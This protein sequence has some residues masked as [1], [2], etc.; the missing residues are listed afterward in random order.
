MNSPASESD[1]GAYGSTLLNLAAECRDDPAFRERLE[2]DPRAVL[3]GRP[4]LTDLPEDVDVRV[5]Y[6][7]E[8]VMYL[9]FPANPNVALTD[10]AIANVTGG[11]TVGSGGTASSGGTLS[12]PTL[13]FSSVG[14]AGTAGSANVNG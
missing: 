11:S 12:C 3:T 6:N 7:A 10:T 4:G 14:C 5:S 1:Y 13:T 2:A 9:V 8:D